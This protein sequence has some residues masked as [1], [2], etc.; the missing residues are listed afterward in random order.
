M[1]REALRRWVLGFA[2][3]DPRGV[4]LVPGPL[5]GR[6]ILPL[7]P[8]AL[9]V[10]SVGAGLGGVLDASGSGTFALP[11]PTD[12]ALAWLSFHAAAFTLRPTAG[13]GAISQGLALQIVR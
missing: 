9:F 3:A 13:V 12:P 6:R 8:D 1:P 7:D 11:I 4:P 10:A 2:F 5:F